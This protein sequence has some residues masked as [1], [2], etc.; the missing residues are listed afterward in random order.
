MFLICA[1]LLIV[2]FYG[3]ISGMVMKFKS[4]A[5]LF[6]SLNVKHP[7]LL[8]VLNLLK[9]AAKIISIHFNFPYVSQ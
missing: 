1:D 3:L 7:K 2:W 9:T 5:N 4:K 6:L 8:I